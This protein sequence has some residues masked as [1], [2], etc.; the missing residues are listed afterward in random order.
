MT[1]VVNDVSQTMICFLG[2][3]ESLF[4]PSLGSASDRRAGDNSDWQVKS[5]MSRR[6]DHRTSS[7]DGGFGCI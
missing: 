6:L 5:T 4:C 1:K 2:S 3:D 7:K